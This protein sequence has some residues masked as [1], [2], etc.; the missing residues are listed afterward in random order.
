MSEIMQQMFWNAAFATLL[1]LTLSV[2]QRMPVL[3]KRPGLRHTLWLVVIFKLISPAVVSVPVASSVRP[4]ALP[5]QRAIAPRPQI[6]IS[7]VDAVRLVPATVDVMVTRAGDSPP[8][9]KAKLTAD[10]GLPKAEQSL[11]EQSKAEQ[12][13]AEQSLASHCVVSP[14]TPA[15]SMPLDLQAFGCIVVVISLLC[16]L[17][18]LLMAF[19]RVRA[20]GRLVR[21]AQRGPRWLEVAA[22]DAAR[23]F[24]L[25]CTP[26]VR[27]VDNHV[28]PFLW[29]TRSGPVIVAPRGLIES[30]DRSGAELIIAHELAHHARRDHLTNSALMIL[31]SLIWWNPVFWWAQREV[32]LVQELCC[33]AM[34]LAGNRQQRGVYAETLLKTV[35]FV[36]SQRTLQTHPAP[37]FGSGT[38]FR[39]RIEMICRSD[40]PARTSLKIRM[41]IGS[42]A[43]LLLC[44]S[45]SV[46][47]E[48]PTTDDSGKSVDQ[49]RTELR[50]VNERL[51][52]LDS[53]VERLLAQELN[54]SSDDDST[55]EQASSTREQ[56]SQSNRSDVRRRQRSVADEPVR[57]GRQQRRPH[58]DR[59]NRDS[60][61]VGDTDVDVEVTAD[62]GS[63]GRDRNRFRLHIR[64]MA[65]VKKEMKKA[66]R[67]VAQAR[68]T[69]NEAQ[70]RMAQTRLN[71]L[72]EAL[73]NL[74]PE[75]ETDIIIEQ[76]PEAPGNIEVKVHQRLHKEDEAARDAAEVAKDRVQ[77][78][79]EQMRKQIEK[80]RPE[81][82]ARIRE[83]AREAAETSR[84]A[85]EAARKQAEQVSNWFTERDQSDAT[86][87]E[88]IEIEIQKDSERSAGNSN[89]TF[90][91]KLRDDEEVASLRALVEE[92]RRE[93][94]TL[95]SEKSGDSAQN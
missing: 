44:A 92:L 4:P 49:L 90:R 10:A 27:I 86:D 13:K 53:L 58:A 62:A 89:H 18:L 15:H 8:A 71:A 57:K 45:P 43:L 69:N 83:I 79:V 21:H 31:G 48:D 6:G 76:D 42:C 61:S 78:S 11:A 65:E 85:A 2:A 26:Q 35:D 46:A 19:F 87:Q 93:I 39:R 60:D 74:S 28:T 12:S 82:E 94:A 84:T 47:S 66:G 40:L 20:I 32:R 17:L 95:R 77:R 64:G 56:A 3:R 59:D 36:S 9:D 33:D 72:R 68:R 14:S 70:A 75:G 55:R 54:T 52:K 41:L 30:L 24:E 88:E 34:V 50:E 37:A 63:Q 16:S 38:T 22:T 29:V 23:Q 73:D 7:R 80:S 81:M 67:E 91:R 25:S 51:S 1:A 5:S